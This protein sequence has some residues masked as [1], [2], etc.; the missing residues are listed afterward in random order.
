VVDHRNF[1]QSNLDQ[2]HLIWSK[3][4]KKVYGNGVAAVN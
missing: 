4:L 1:V 3:N 2:N